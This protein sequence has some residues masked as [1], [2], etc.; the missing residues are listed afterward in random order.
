MS[1]FPSLPLL[2]SLVACTAAPERLSPAGIELPAPFV[3]QDELHACGLSAVS[4]LCAY[5]G[6]EL[7]EPLRLDLARLSREN[8]GLS[9]GELRDALED[10]GFEVF[11]F[12]GTTGAGTTGLPRHIGAGRPV[13]VLLEADG[14]AHYVLVTGH[15]P[16]DGRLVLL[17][18]RRG[19]VV[20]PLTDFERQWEPTQRL[21]L[22]A[23]PHRGAHLASP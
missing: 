16:L 9:A 7:P 13:L 8:L 2:L 15:D 21:A 6:V 3:A 10:L 5:H 1:R 23:V 18:P 19:R 20:V 17:D 14:S 22:L 4:A 12:Q 11:L